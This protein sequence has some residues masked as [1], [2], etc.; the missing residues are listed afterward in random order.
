MSKA[1]LIMDMPKSC[2]DCRLS[3]NGKIC[4]DGNR[5]IFDIVEKEGVLT[6]KYIGL[7]AKPDW[8]QLR[9]MPKKITERTRQSTKSYAEGY[10]DCIDEILK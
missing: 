1:M 8:C 7:T 10:N 5:L 2:A 4:K 9:K 6:Q 3:E